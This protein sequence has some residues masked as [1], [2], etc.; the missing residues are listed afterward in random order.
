MQSF[1]CFFYSSVQHTSSA[2]VLFSNR[3][4]IIRVHSHFVLLFRE[5]LYSYIHANTTKNCRII[6]QLLHSTTQKTRMTRMRNDRHRQSSIFQAISYVS[7]HVRWI[8]SPHFLRQIM[9]VAVRKLKLT[10]IGC[11]RIISICCCVDSWKRVLCLGILYFR[12]LEDGKR[13]C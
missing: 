12:I 11:F 8:S 4:S 1:F 3:K 5:I 6:F 13:P 10:L 7:P 9:R 2:I